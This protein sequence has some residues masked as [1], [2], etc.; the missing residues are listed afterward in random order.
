MKPEKEEKIG[1]TLCKLAPIHIGHFELFDFAL[2]VVDKL[3]LVLYDCPNLIDIP[4][5]ARAEWVRKL[6]PQIEVIEGWDAP[7]QHEDTPEVKRMQEQYIFNVLKGRKITHF[8][9]SEYYGE[10]MSKFL[11]AKN[12]VVD[13][14]RKKFHMSSTMVRSNPYLYRDFVPTMVYRDLLTKVVILGAPSEIN[15]ELAK[16]VAKKEETVF[17]PDLTLE[18]LTEQMTGSTMSDPDF[19][20]VAI[21]KVEQRSDDKII[22]S[23]KKSIVYSSATIMDHVLSIAINRKFDRK[24]FDIAID[25]IRNFDLV[26]VNNDEVNLASKM[27]GIKNEFFMNQL[28]G[29]LDDLKI[30]YVILNGDSDK[31]IQTIT[32]SI[33]VINNSKKFS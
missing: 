13:I 16:R 20:S 30:K 5:N 19:E 21:K 28:I 23:A 26:F 31:K 2:K 29:N 32:K 12:V 8:I 27:F 14:E 33:N 9:S 4:L 18:Y 15:D 25:D 1:L 6:Y 7:N 22:H 11:N 24:L 10:H 17:I 3:I